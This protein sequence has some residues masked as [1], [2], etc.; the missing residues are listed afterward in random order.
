VKTTRDFLLE[1]DLRDIK[2]WADGDQLRINAPKGKLTPELV[3]DLQRRKADLLSILRRTQAQG[4]RFPSLQRVSGQSGL[5]LSYAQERMWLL[6]QLGSGDAYNI[7]T[8]LRLRGLLDVPALQRSLSEIVRR[9]EILRTTYV[10]DQGEVSQMV[11]PAGPV[12]LPVTELA[13]MLEQEQ[14][15][16]VERLAR[17]E[18]HRPFDLRHDLLLRCR[19]LRF[20]DT[21]HVLVAVVHHIAADGWS[22]GVLARELSVLYAAFTQGHPSPLPELSIQYADY[23]Y[24]Q[25]QWLQGE[26]LEELIRYWQGQL[27]GA[28]PL[29]QL[30]T[31]RPRPAQETYQGGALAVTLDPKLMNPLKR[32]G[33]ETGTTLFMVLLA[34]FQTLLARYTAQDD[35]V[36]GSPIANRREQA[37]EPLIGCFVNTLALRV[38][39]AGNPTFRTVLERVR[40]TTQ[41]AYEQQDLPFEKLVESLQQERSINYNPLVQVAFALQNT[42]MPPLALPNLQVSALAL[43]H[44]RVRFDIELSL[45]EEQ[46]E[47]RGSCN[48]STALFDK[49]TIERMVGHFE[50]LL[51]AA[52]ADP[53]QPIGRLRMLSE[54]EREQLLVGWNETAR[55]FPGERTIAEMFEAQAA[56]KPQAIALEYQA[57]SQGEQVSYGELNRRANRVAHRLREMGVGRNEAVGLC[58]EQSVE[59]IVGMLAILKA[60]G[61][62]VPL[63]PAFPAER[64]AFMLEETQARVVVTQ[65]GLVGKL[66]GERMQILCLDVERERIESAGAE[67]LGL[68]SGGEGL[69]YILYTSGSTGQPKGIAIPQRAVLRL[70]CDTDYVELSGERRIGQA[71][72]FAF[73]AI[74]FEVWGALLHGA[75]LVQVD[76]ETLLS[77][78][79]LAARL[80]AGRIDTLFLTTALFNQAASSE[81]TAFASLR[82][83]LFGGEAVDARWVREV[84]ARGKPEHLLH[85]YGPTETTTFATWHE[86]E[87]VEGDATSVPIGRPI[88]NTTAYVLDGEREPAAVGVAGELY[89]GGAGVAKGYVARPEL[90]EEKFVAD[91]YAGQAGARLYRTGDWVRRRADGALEFVGRM[92][93]QV[94][95]RGY[96]IEP[97]EVNGVIGGYEAVQESVVVVRE[98][99]G[100]RRLAAYVAPRPG[101]TI[102]PRRL[103][104]YLLEKLPDYMVPAD[105]VVMDALPLNA[106]GKV[107]RHA[108][109]P[110]TN[111]PLGEPADA[112][113]RAL[114]ANETRMA[115]IWAEVLRRDRIGLFDNFFDLGGHSLLATQVVSRIEE[116][117]ETAVPLLTLFEAPTIAGLVERIETLRWAADMP[118]DMTELPEQAVIGDL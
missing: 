117:F 2:L 22:M 89:L 50:R 64:L 63:S 7:P 104:A 14:A 58:M 76:R 45:W 12:A 5:P 72:N 83:L 79:R 32:L 70:V 55:S 90:N 4:R 39:L 116:E 38:S 19:L 61:G 84:V 71:S 111:A 27:A 36:V 82:Y 25:R 20:G 108:L 98:A 26:R 107:D 67:N 105:Y 102:E 60:G 77:P 29:L 80:R 94:K 66:P 15:E 40:Q 13:P 87:A 95:I 73:D 56:R 41:A 100:E 46:G 28:P 65:S 75:C 62:Y 31:D 48:Y 52:V 17:L 1:L 9:H 8:L 53:G 47:L 51:T 93:N 21:D 11:A 96:R 57:G 18:A 112:A 97:E 59:M 54:V 110:L 86:V 74:T 99:E 49:F 118:N 81:P 10:A 109:P 42:P 6:D 91:P 3:A 16:E 103:R 44:Q 33:Q 101:R 23:A 43:D 114:T 24:W 78:Q 37:L 69:A 113:D 35:I 92:D 106:N 34:A 30:P 68:A 115:A 88:A 85:V